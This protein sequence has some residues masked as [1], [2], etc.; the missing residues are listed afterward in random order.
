MAEKYVGNTGILSGGLF[1]KSLDNWIYTFRDSDFT[2]NGT[3]Y[4]R[5]TQRRNGSEASV[6]GFELAAQTQLL[7]NLNLAANYTFTDSS[8]DNILEGRSDV[9]LAGAV[10]NMYCLLYTSP[11]P[12]DKRQSRMPSSA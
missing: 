2:Y 8:T 4:E 10:E 5:F 6:F 1:Y 7:D 9:P 11:S 3:T 12:R